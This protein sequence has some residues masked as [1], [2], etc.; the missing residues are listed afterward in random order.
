MEPYASQVELLVSIPGIDRMAAWH[1]LAELGIDL[2][3][4]PDAAYCCSWAKMIPGE[5]RECGHAERAADAVKAITDAALTN[6]SD[7]GL[8][9]QAPTRWRP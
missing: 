3:A 6:V 2:K 7:D 9:D 8:R 5:K 1:V 4:V